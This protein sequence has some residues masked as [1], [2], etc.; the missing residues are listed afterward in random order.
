MGSDKSVLHD[1]A[2]IIVF[3]DQPISDV[4]HLFLMLCDELFQM[5]EDFLFVQNTSVASSSGPE[6]LL[7]L[8]ISRVAVG[9]SV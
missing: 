9:F 1:L 2:L 3:P 8:L 6:A 4:E 5:P 7:L